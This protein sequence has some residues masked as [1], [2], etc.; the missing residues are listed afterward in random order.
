MPGRAYPPGVRFIRESLVD[1][2]TTFSSG[3]C[4]MQVGLG[5]AVTIAPNEVLWPVSGCRQT[6]PVTLGTLTVPDEA[7]CT[8]K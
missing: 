8:A 1:Q 2:K 6:Y 4:L 5:K 7:A 3:P